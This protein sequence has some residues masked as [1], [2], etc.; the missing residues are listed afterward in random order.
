MA[1]QESYYT[2]AGFVKFP[3]TKINDKEYGY[4]FN[5]PGLTEDD[6]CSWKFVLTL[7]PEDKETQ[8]LL[9]ML[10]EQHKKI[11]GANFNPYKDDKIKNDDGEIVLSGLVGINFTTSYPLTIVDAQK[12]K[13]DLP[14]GW[15]S[16]V[17][18]KFTTKPVNNKGKVG[19][20]RYAR[21]L[22]VIDLIE[23]GQDLS[24]FKEEEDGFKAPQDNAVPWDE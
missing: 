9:A 23:S 22:Q 10:D 8:D 18:V 19:L 7:D 20:G 1:K 24:G 15:G 11:K 6:I 13:M 4:L 12:N 3:K 16:K 14:V 17:R 5:P 2:P 21:A